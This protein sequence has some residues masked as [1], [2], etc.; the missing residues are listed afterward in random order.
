MGIDLSGKCI[1]SCK[2]RFGNVSHAQFLMNDGMSLDPLPDDTFDLVFSFDSLVH[3]EAEVLDSYIRQ[4]LQKLAPQG[5]AFVH[6]SNVAALPP[7]EQVPHGRSPSVSA[8]T[9]ASAV[10]DAGGM[11]LFKESLIGAAT[12]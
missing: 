7:T 4:M 9:V 8:E 2:S 12:T 6:H 5:I 11:C 1:E 10:R 3:A